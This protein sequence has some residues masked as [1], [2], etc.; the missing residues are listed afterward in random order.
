MRHIIG[1]IFAVAAFLLVMM[2]MPNTGAIYTHD[3]QSY[4]YAASTLLE[5]GQLKYF[6]Y[7]TP[8]VQWPP[9]YILIIAVIRFFGVSLEEGAMWINAICFAYLLYACANWLYSCL[10]VKWLTIPALV[11]MLASVPLV[12]VSGYAWTEMLFIFLSVLAMMFML[13]FIHRQKQGWLIAA[14]VVS[15]LGWLTRYIGIVMIGVLAIMLFISVRP[16]ARKFKL[17][18]I[19]LAFSCGPMSLWVLRNYLISGTFTGGRQPGLFT[20]ADNIELSIEV[21]RSWNSYLTPVFPFIAMVLLLSLIAITFFLEKKKKK[22]AEQPTEICT[23]ILFI[24]FYAITLL[25][26]ATNTAM[27]PINT[28][29]W[30]PIY[31]FWVFLLVF[32]MDMLIRNVKVE[33]LKQWIAAGFAVFTLVTAINP[34]FWIQTVGFDR[35]HAMMGAKRDIGQIY[36]PVLMLA[37][38]N[39]PATENTL[40]ISNNCSLLTTHSNLKSFYPPKK[41]GIPL[42]SFSRYKEQLDNFRYIYL[43]W[44][45]PVESDDFMDVADFHR[46]YEMEKIAQNNYCVIYRLK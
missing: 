8:V 33:S 13:Q 28:R 34:F 40:V 39:I 27:D 9:F 31:P 20:L 21:F 14:S 11:L 17:T 41:D 46:R 23:I 32:V 1:V 5:T 10:K 7:D 2:C 25:I 6:G 30:A 19:Y 38:E 16:I 3:S 42:Y 37:T 12:M 4:E 43:L 35:K 18:F 22:K 44:H 36:S 24:A 15:A 26:S 45:G 29:L